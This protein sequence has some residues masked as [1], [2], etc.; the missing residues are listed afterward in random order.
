[1]V[2]AEMLDLIDAQIRAARSQPDRP[3]GGLQ[4]IMFGD[5]FQL[6]PIQ[7]D[8]AVADGSVH[9]ER[10]YT[11]AGLAFQSYFW[12]E[13]QP[14][15]CNLQRSFRQQDDQ[16]FLDALQRIR[17][18]QLNA[19]DRALLCAP[20]A[21]MQSSQASGIVPT[22]LFCKKKDVEDDNA[23]ELAKLP[24]H[25]V[26]YIAHD[27]AKETGKGIHPP[28]ELHLKI[29][30][31]VMLVKNLDVKRGLVN[32]SRGVVVGFKRIVVAPPF[33]RSDPEAE[34]TQAFQSMSLHCDIREKVEDGVSMHPIV[35]FDGIE[36]PQTMAPLSFKF[37]ENDKGQCSS[38]LQVPLTLAWA[39]SIHKAQGMSISNLE[40][41]TAQAWDF[42]QMYVALSRGR[43]L[44]GLTVR[45]LGADDCCK[46]NPKVLDF[47]ESCERGA[48]L[49]TS[50]DMWTDEATIAAIR[51]AA[52]SKN[53][54]LP[55]QQQHEGGGGGGGGSGGG[56]AAAAAV[57]AA[58]TATAAAAAAQSAYSSASCGGGVGDP[59]NDRAPHA[60]V[61]KFH[62][63][64]ATIKDCDMQ[65]VRNATAKKTWSKGGLNIDEI[66]TLLAPMGVDVSRLAK[67]RDKAEKELTSL[68]E[69]LGLK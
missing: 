7:D 66:T 41:D 43:T 67:D 68:L 22:K 44:Q 31:Q 33:E 42:G 45:A 46:A 12:K 4:V 53:P 23:V 64:V 65:R 10:I 62:T 59:Q 17:L 6:P 20:K 58:A 35:R 60:D 28:R 1:M 51:R 19:H 55:A 8:A 25:Q 37:N 47:Y 14:E 13:L 52:F 39:L 30:A 63:L 32:G 27:S 15:F 48:A 18:G 56:A 9:P 26:T 38:R 29:G 40:V 61:A 2:S 21:Q 24:G 49:Q 16:P 50:V 11:S 34:L 5:F 69:R 57:A 36:Q 54:A 3:F